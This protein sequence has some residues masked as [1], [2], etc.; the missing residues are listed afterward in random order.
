MNK[1]LKKRIYT[2]LILF[3]LFFLTFNSNFIMTYSLIVLGALS[4]IEFLNIT[5][6]IFKNKIYLFTSNFFL[7]FLFLYSV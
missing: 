4:I 5:N 7:Y 6:K 3:L 1:N 2:S